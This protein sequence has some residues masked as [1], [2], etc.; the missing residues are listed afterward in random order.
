[1]NKTEQ[2]I[3]HLVAHRGDMTRYPENTLLALSNALQL[4]AHIEFDLQLNATGDFVVIHDDNFKR[5]AGID[6][7][8]LESRTE[9]L[10]SISVHQPNFHLQK[11][12]PQ[13]VPLLDDVL[14]L[15]SLYPQ[16]K[17]FVEIKEESLHYRGVDATMKPLLEKLALYSEQCIL[18][19]FNFDAIAY[20]KKHSNLP[21]GWVLKRYNSIYLKWAKQLQP[22]YLICNQRKL[23]FFKQPW[24]GDWQWML[25]DILK[26]MKAVNYIQQGIVFI[27]TGDIE[28]M[29]RSLLHPKQARSI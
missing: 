12:F 26:P 7:S 29:A 22:D 11:Y 16:V 20:T 10:N 8:V 13:P 27:E 2:L 25:Y 9:D 14:N 19:S 4:G 6:V 3:T 28:G 17:A 24:S 5:T 18:I 15:L 1:M 23:P 21:V